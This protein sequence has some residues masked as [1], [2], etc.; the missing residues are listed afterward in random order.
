MMPT[1]AAINDC[2]SDERGSSVT[3]L[4][5]PLGCGLFSAR[6]L[7][8][9]EIV[10]ASRTPLLTAAR[11]LLAKGLP[12]K[13]IIEIR[14]TGA[15]TW[16]L[17]APID[18][19]AG[20]DVREGPYGPKFVR[21]REPREGAVDCIKSTV[22]APDERRGVCRRCRSQAHHQNHENGNRLAQIPPTAE[23]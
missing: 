21:Y 22:G 6:T 20:L 7:A 8:G 12:P 16:D 5:A 17:R 23:S 19:A 2:A 4:V 1:S 9:R 18:I 15:V 10:S 11:V 13:A 14:R 3:V